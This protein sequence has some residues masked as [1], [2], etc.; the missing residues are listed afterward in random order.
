MFHVLGFKSITGNIDFV[1]EVAIAIEIVIAIEIA[2]VLL[3]RSRLRSPFWMFL[4]D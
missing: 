3:F 4:C 1:I 2:I